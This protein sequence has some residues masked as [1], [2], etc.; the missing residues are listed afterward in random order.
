MASELTR[1]VSRGKPFVRAA[2]IES[3]Y[4]PVRFVLLLQLLNEA[5]LHLDFNLM[6]ET[7]APVSGPS[8][9]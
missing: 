4:C 9:L 2:C 1:I 3:L 5:V 7:I 6:H 8:A